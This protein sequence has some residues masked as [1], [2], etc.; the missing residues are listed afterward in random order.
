MKRFLIILFLMVLLLTGLLMSC[1]RNEQTLTGAA[2]PKVN[3]I[4]REYR[5]GP[6]CVRVSVDKDSMSIAESV[7]LTIEAEIEEGYEVEL[8]K[9]GEKL[10]EFGI[11]DYRDDPPR[12][13]PEGK[14]VSRKIY[15]LDPFLSGDYTISPLQVKFRK[16]ADAGG[17]QEHELS[18]E[19][20][21]IKVTSLLE[22]DQKEPALNPIKGPVDLPRGP[23]SS[24]HILLGVGAIAIV[25]GGVFLFF[26]QKRTAKRRNAAPPIPAHELA[27]RQL[28]EILD[29]KLIER[30]E[31]K[32]FFSK[33]SDVLRGYI[34]NRFGIHA[35]RRTTEEFLSDISLVAPFSVEHR[36]LL[37]EFLSNCDLV[38]FAE[39]APSQGEVG[40][41]VDA[42]KNF[43]EATRGDAVMR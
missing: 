40:M 8:P 34:E 9:F 22:Q 30:R 15:T 16:K 26:R 19:E 31:I 3:E 25:A 41:A 13:T 39:H 1:G 6:L 37:S 24:L 18:T 21:T 17:S 12:L 4:R 27:Y 11:K 35:P 10:D 7:V 43:I 20:I 38:K 29:E 14:I 32:L 23:V 2:Q 42:C 33:V 28:Q 5:K 36:R